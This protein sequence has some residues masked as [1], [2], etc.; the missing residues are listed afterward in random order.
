MNIFK[1]LQLILI[2][3]I[4]SACNNQTSSYTN[5]DYADLKKLMANGAV[6]VDVRTAQEWKHTGVIAGS[7]TLS[8]FLANGKINPDFVPQLQQLVKVDDHLIV[9]CRSGGRSGVASDFITS[10]LGYKNV[11]NVQNGIMGWIKQGYPVSSMGIN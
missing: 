9:M 1:S 7:K 5:I 11:Y 4:L 3:L 10:K 2:I 8:F 6:L